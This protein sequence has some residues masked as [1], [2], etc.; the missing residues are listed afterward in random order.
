MRQR[1]FIL[2]FS[3]SFILPFS[4]SLSF[5]LFSLCVFL[6][7]SLSTL[8]S[9]SCCSSWVR[10]AALGCATRLPGAL[11]ITTA[12]A[13]LATMAA[14]PKEALKGALRAEKIKLWEP[15]Y[16]YVH[17]QAARPERQRACIV[18]QACPLDRELLH[19]PGAGR[20]DAWRME[21]SQGEE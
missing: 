3:L 8:F 14:T 18:S 20:K 5:S 21:Q 19:S 11:S 15:P 13:L 2:P 1:H 17:G 16:T 7:Y 12:S 4:L 9:V 6:L 10:V